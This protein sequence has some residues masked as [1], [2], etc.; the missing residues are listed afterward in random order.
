LF[1]S[2]SFNTFTIFSMEER[3]YWLAFSVFPGIGTVTFKKLLQRF[4]SAKNAWNASESDLQEFIQ[5]RYMKKFIDFR[6][7][8]PFDGY[9]NELQRKNV[10]FVTLQDKEYPQLLKKIIKPPFVLY[11]KGNKEI[12]NQVQN[13]SFLAVVGTRKITE[14]GREVTELFTRD[15][16]QNGIT[17]VSGL[18]LGVDALAHKTTL[19]NNGYTIAV[20]GCGVDCCTPEEN[21]FLYNEILKKGGAIVSEFPLNHPPT[22]GSFPARNR[23]IAG[24]SD[25]VL[26]TEGAEDS[27]SLITADYA[28]KFNR[29][30]F[31]VPGPVTSG[32]SKGPF[33]LIQRGAKL[34]TSA[35]DIAEELK[36]QVLNVKTTTQSSNLKEPRA[37]TREERKI[38]EM[39][40][41]EALHFDT[42]ARETGFS[43]SKL[44]SLLTLMEMKGMIKNSQGMFSSYQE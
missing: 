39:L 26:V 28:F 22:Q 12:L 25:G 18:A 19:E 1:L 2:N 31:A 13:D 27:G 9:Q 20:L 30:V 16:V 35:K 10:W 29:P 14:Y 5:E 42:I 32:M 38:L 8:F 7:S 21:Q 37:G 33:R 4:G 40:E 6:S 41:N 24:L 43:S 15:L 44:G 36:S 23:I 3:T 17:I 34:V 11:A